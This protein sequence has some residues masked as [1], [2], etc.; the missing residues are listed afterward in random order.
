[1]HPIRALTSKVRMTE[2]AKAHL[3][4]LTSERATSSGVQV[5]YSVGDFVTF[6]VF[7]AVTG[8]ALALTGVRAPSAD[9]LLAAVAILTG[10]LFALIV[11][12]FD[13]VKKEASHPAPQAGN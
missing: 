13:Q 2:I 10:L 1:M 5:E 6:G 4:T 9:A 8:V 3:A 12:V 7:P 11:M